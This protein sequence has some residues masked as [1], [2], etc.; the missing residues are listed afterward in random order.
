[1]SEK[2]LEQMGLRDLRAIAREQ[3]PAEAWHHFNGGAET[4]ATFYRN[5]RSFQK[6]LFR[7]RI[8][9]DVTDPDIS[10]D[11]VRQPGCQAQSA[12]LAR[13]D[14][15][16]AGLDG[17]HEPRQRRSVAVREAVPRPRLRCGR[18]YDGYG[19]P[20]ENRRPSA[21]VNQGRQAEKRAHGFAE[22]H[23]VDETAGFSARGGERHHG[24][25]G[26]AC[27]GKRRR[28]CGCRV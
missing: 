4:K 23:R 12:G 7:Q 1:M 10:V 27:G 25:R 18:Y 28:G 21:V 20:G 2:P 17:L 26:R 16:T 8:F 15:I 13:C 14:S 9:H 5:P 3:M 22:G 19:S 11:D 24:S 6:Y